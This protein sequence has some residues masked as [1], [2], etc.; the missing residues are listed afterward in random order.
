MSYLRDRSGKAS[1]IIKDD[2][3]RNPGKTESF[4]VKAGY[5]HPHTVM[6]ETG[7]IAEPA[8][9]LVYDNIAI[10]R[11]LHGE[12]RLILRKLIPHGRR[13][14]LHVPKIGTKILRQLN[15]IPAISGMAIGIDGITQKI[16]LLQFFVELKS[17]RRKNHSLRGANPKRASFS[18][19]F[20]FG[21]S[22]TG[23]Q[24]F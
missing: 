20:H 3:R 13:H 5:L 18:F 22:F 6:F 9:V 24:Y 19:R 1:W 15:A 4:P 11:Y 14:R 10:R 21:D 2:I 8:P 16:F 7:F 23:T 12:R 17:T